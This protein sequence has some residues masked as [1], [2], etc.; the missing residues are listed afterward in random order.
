MAD[1]FVQKS[2]VAG[3]VLIRENTVLTE[4]FIIKVG[5]CKI[6][7]SSIFNDND[8][9][10]FEN[11]EEDPSKTGKT[12]KGYFSSTTNE[13]Q[14]GYLNERE[15]VGNEIL[16][17]EDHPVPFSVIAT[18]YVETLA[19]TRNEINSKSFP[20][21]IRDQVHEMAKERL[22]FIQQR[23]VD[24]SKDL[25]KVNKWDEFHKYY[26]DKGK[27]VTKKFPAANKGAL[28]NFRT[29]NIVKDPSES[30]RMS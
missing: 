1:C 30:G 3:Q 8:E 29:L 16:I 27:E 24:I 17:Y 7:S 28:N 22:K 19:I 10:D 11:Y 4:A 13:F 20:R 21:D 15:W 14:L 5:Q 2:Y 26:D 6:V 9:E 12:D 23:V 18:N 25:K